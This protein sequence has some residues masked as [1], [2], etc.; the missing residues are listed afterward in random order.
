[1]TERLSRITAQE[2]D[3]GQS[4][5]DPSDVSSD[6][7]T[8]VNHARLRFVD[9]SD[10]Y[11]ALVLKGLPGNLAL[12]PYRVGHGRHSVVM[13]SIDHPDIVFKIAAGSDNGTR[14]PTGEFNEEKVNVFFHSQGIANT[15]QL[16]AVENGAIVATRMPGVTLYSFDY[17]DFF[18]QV[19]EEQVDG[20]LQTMRQVMDRGLTLEPEP[21]N[22][23]YDPKAGFSLVD[24]EVSQ[25]GIPNVDGVIDALVHSLKT[26]A[27]VESD[28]KGGLDLPGTQRLISLL[29]AH[30]R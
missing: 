25:L 2:P 9:Y 22:I 21:E 11:D 17:D 29:E 27:A 8:F 24:L 18:E 16:V 15:E 7:K 4:L 6:Y 28:M 20:L 14:T 30:T 10:E 13:E 26:E 5:V 12:D 1:M 23:M 3:T 19:T